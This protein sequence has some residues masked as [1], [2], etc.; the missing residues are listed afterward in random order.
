MKDWYNRVHLADSIEALNALSP[1]TVQADLVFADPPYN[2]GYSYDVY[3][4]NLDDEAYV[5][6]T[7][8]WMRAAS[9]VLKPSG[10]FWVAIG[11][12]YVAETKIAGEKAGL[13]LRN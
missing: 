11:D 4:D 13:H 10:A 9:R 6:W 8:Q 3:Q 2:I 1:K 12:E 7:G 5:Q